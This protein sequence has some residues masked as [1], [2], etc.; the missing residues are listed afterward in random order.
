VNPR[1]AKA[2]AH[3][4]PLNVISP[5]FRNDSSKTRGSSLRGYDFQ[6]R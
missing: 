6:A 2:R 3:F 4:A 1:T 5:S